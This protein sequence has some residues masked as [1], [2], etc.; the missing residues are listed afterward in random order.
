MLTCGGVI[1]NKN[2]TAI[3]ITSQE[4]PMIEEKN[5]IEEL[6]RRISAIMEHL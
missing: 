3:I 2:D 5:R 4:T 6:R 1:C